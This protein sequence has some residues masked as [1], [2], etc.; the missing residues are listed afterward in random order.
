M[1]N[2][3]TMFQP[4]AIDNALS[5]IQII[6]KLI[7]E[8]NKV[9][10]VLN[11]IDSKA[12][13]Y[14]DEQIHKLDSKLTTEYK[15]DIKYEVD[16]LNKKIKELNDYEIEL[17]EKINNVNN[18]NRAYTDEK[19][20]TLN[21]LLNENVKSIYSSLESLRKS[22]VA[23]SDSLYK[24]AIKKIDEAKKEIYDVLEK[25]GG[26]KCYSPITGEFE[27]V[28]DILYDITNLFLKRHLFNYSSLN[29]ICSIGSNQK[30]LS[31]KF[32]NN[33]VWYLDEQKFTIIESLSNLI[34]VRPIFKAG[35]VNS[36]LRIVNG[37]TSNITD[38]CEIINDSV[39]I[40]VSYLKV[41]YDEYKKTNECKIRVDT[42]TGSNVMTLFTFYDNYVCT[43]DT[44]QYY[45]SL[46]S[47]K[48]T[49]EDIDL[50][51]INALYNII[52]SSKSSNSVPL[53][54]LDKYINLVSNYKI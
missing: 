50:Y 24:D 21:D 36:I 17:N 39:K 20:K 38:K 32:D 51:G 4:S 2:H 42:N 30:S 27:T 7:N 8:I 34:Y 13:E 46:S 12:N 19:F 31:Y 40:P 53:I 47:R 3:I 35:S 45:A 9:I 15:A 33:D 49:Y 25:W 37:V 41:T 44:L 14:T 54:D 23:Y 28:K 1:L 6:H 5:T 22:L 18:K 16:R 11:D 48:V 52:Y 43:Y 10:D 26:S 29:Y